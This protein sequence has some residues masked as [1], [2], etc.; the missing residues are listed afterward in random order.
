[1]GWISGCI[2]KS[3]RQ[4]NDKQRMSEEKNEKIYEKNYIIFTKNYDIA[5]KIDVFFRF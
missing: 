1:M 2:I 5:I 3:L 4:K